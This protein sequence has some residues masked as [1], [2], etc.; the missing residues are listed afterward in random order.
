MSED[1]VHNSADS[2]PIEF[3]DM[4]ERRRVLFGLDVIADLTGR[5]AQ[6]PDPGGA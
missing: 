6:L 1:E 4:K 3:H 5:H 2:F